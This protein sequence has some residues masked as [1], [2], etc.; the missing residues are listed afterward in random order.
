MLPWLST[1]NALTYTRSELHI[2]RGH[3]PS[4]TGFIMGHEFTG[5]VVQVG[6]AVKTIKI[7]DKVVAPFTASW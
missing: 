3:Q 2:Y 1:M 7:G 4:D 5:T 6:P